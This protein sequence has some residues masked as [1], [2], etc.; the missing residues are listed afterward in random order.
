MRPKLIEIP[1]PFIGAKIPVFGYGLMLIIGVVVA[2]AL[3]A[4]AGRRRGIP[5]EKIWDFGVYV[6]L[7]GILGARILFFIQYYRESFAGKPLYTVF[8][9][10]EGGLVLYGGVVVAVVA[11][12]V[13]L[14]RQ[15]IPLTSFLDTIGPYAPLGLAFGRLGCLLN[16][17]CWGDLVGEGFPVGIRFPAGSLVYHAQE[18]LGFAL[19]GSSLPVQ[20]AQVYASL[21]AFLLFGLLR[22]YVAG[23]PPKGSVF[24]V[25]GICYGVGRFVLE[26]VRDDVEAAAVGLT[27]AQWIS[28]GIIIVSI[29]FLM[30]VL[31]SI[32][33]APSPRPAS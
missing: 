13:Y 7:F 26:I 32:S 12:Y 27:L 31:R 8:Y 28:I 19:G 11:G 17:C 21:H 20:P 6:V 14:R 23:H 16:G 1:I 29:F 3:A 4:R 15:R 18:R 9:I 5:P 24:P 2:T 22:W 30:R 10:W 33:L 25:L